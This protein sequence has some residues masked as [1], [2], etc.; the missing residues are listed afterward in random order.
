MRC[1]ALRL[2]RH[3]GFKPLEERASPQAS[4]DLT[5]RHDGIGD[6]RLGGIEEGR[7]LDG[8]E[9]LVEA[10]TQIAEAADCVVVKQE[11]VCLTAIERGFVPASLARNA[12]A[13]RATR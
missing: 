6:L 1:R 2:V 3:C 9:R 13:A 10:H 12:G 7:H 11:S 4:Q 5:S 8:R